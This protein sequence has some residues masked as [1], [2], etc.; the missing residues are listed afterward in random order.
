MA[1]EN[2]QRRHWHIGREIPVAVL[3]MLAA[4]TVAFVVWIAGLAKTVENQGVAIAKIELTLKELTGAVANPMGA[5]NAANIAALEKKLN[6]LESRV[7]FVQKTQADRTV[8]IP[9]RPQ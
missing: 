7:D 4:Q 9:K 3:V 2:E 8:Y 1:D 5:I 6:A